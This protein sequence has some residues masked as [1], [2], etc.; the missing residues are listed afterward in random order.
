MTSAQLS[1]AFLFQ[2]VNILHKFLFFRL[3][4]N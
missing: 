1:E 3:M 4:E 2:E